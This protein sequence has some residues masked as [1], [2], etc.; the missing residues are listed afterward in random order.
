MLKFVD[1]KQSIQKSQ[2]QKMKTLYLDIFSGI[3]G[4]MFLGAM[5]DLGLPEKTLTAELNKLG[6]DEYRLK[7]SRK[8]RSQIEGVQFEVILTNSNSHNSH[9]THEH[10]EHD[11]SHVHDHEHSHSRNFSQ[12]KNIIRVSQL[13]DFVKKN[14]IECFARIAR[15]EGK[16]HGK[17]IDEVHFHEV[18]AIDSIVDI[19]GACI[20]IEWLGK[21]R[22]LASRIV[23][24]TG[25]VACAH[26]RFPV[27][28]MATLAIL[29]ERRIALNQCE[30]PHEM[31]T[32]TGAALLAQFVDCFGLMKNFR[33]KQIGF[34]IGSRDFKSRPNVLRAILG[35]NAFSEIEECESDEVGIVECNL[36][37]VS[38]E[39]LG[40]VM[41]KAFEAGAL[42][43]FHI[44]IQMKKQRPGILF[45]I[46][47][48]SDEIA[49]FVK[50]ILIETSSFGVRISF[51]N[52]YKLRR[53]RREIQTPFGNVAAQIG[54]FGGRAIRISPEYDACA[55]LAQSQN[56]PLQHILQSIP[57][58]PLENA[59]RTN[60][61][62]DQTDFD[63]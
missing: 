55:K 8:Q 3:A 10:H 16:I 17:P 24:G 28:T 9:K 54:Y 38:A 12:I 61:H 50:L 39:I 31:I 43:A 30:E 45:T 58:P 49:D 23:E 62:N 34:G 2:F 35:E 52:R 59:K 25:W 56:I 7:I 21:P 53:E 57:S 51:A 36:D 60:R 48:R 44:P 11:H 32:P 47:C 22:V 37:D 1:S 6:L 13:S 29:A 20:A 15:A 5:L 26:G 14:S 63:E 33:P 4:D 19:V 18:G 46:L 40:H 41:Q 27:P 42:D